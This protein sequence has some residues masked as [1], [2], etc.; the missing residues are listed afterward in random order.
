MTCGAEGT[1]GKA[2]GKTKQNGDPITDTVDDVK[3]NSP[4]E[5]TSAPRYR[6]RP[7]SVPI[8]PAETCDADRN[9]RPHS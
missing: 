1:G 2:S 8:V 9:N 5:P 6:F 4:T 3:K 7:S